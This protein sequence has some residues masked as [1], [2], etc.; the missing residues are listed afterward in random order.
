[1]VKTY[2]VTIATE[3]KYYLPYLKKTC[4]KYGSELIILAYGEKWQG[5]NWRN[6]LV[7]N[8]LNKLNNDDIVCVIDGY[9]VICVRNLDQFA[10][11]FIKI[12]NKYNCK[13]IV[14]EHNFVKNNSYYLKNF[15]HSLYFG[16]CKN[17]FICAGTYCGYVS[18]LIDYIKN[19]QYIDDSNKA[20]DQKL[21]TK[22]CKLNP[23]SIYID[24]N[25]E[26]FVSLENKYKNIDDNFT[27]KNN[28][29]YFNEYQ[30]F[31]IHGPGE[32]YL[33]NILIKMNLDYD[34]NNKICDMLS[35]DYINK[36][37]FRLKNNNIL[38]FFILLLFIIFIILFIMNKKKKNRK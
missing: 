12:K 24:T 11:S 19:I 4:K 2:I 21:L 14:G 25:G 5:F 1:M 16:N 7:L 37:I 33:D 22:Y 31:F 30:P 13:I 10:N 28:N 9:D 27:Y 23:D 18:D 15:I 32:T 20:D 35:K 6:K 29:I 26:L 36:Q 38:I 8:F 34:N 17:K 3:D